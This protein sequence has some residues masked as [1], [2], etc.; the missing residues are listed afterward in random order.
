MWS[1]T[2]SSRAEL[3]KA[4]GLVLSPGR[5]HSG[6]AAPC[7]YSSLGRAGLSLSAPCHKWCHMALEHG[8]HIGM[9]LQLMGL[10]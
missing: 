4:A 2:G 6:V 10:P 5:V 7:S 9:V 8:H 3:T 1:Q